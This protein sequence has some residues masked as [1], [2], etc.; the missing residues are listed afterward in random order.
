MLRVVPDKE[1]LHTKIDNKD[2]YADYGA[3]E[4]I[5]EDVCSL[6]PAAGMEIWKHSTEVAD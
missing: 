2:F 6:K 4:D 1:I 5:P 3:T